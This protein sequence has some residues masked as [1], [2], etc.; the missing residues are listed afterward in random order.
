M[1]SG[2]GGAYLRF[3]NAGLDYIVF[4]KL[5]NHGKD[6]KQGVI[7][8][9]NGKR[10]TSLACRSRSAQFNFASL[11]VPAEPTTEPLIDDE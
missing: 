9:K 1:Y 5:T 3:K 6:E 8:A 7:V 11:P 4:S 10:I 2:G